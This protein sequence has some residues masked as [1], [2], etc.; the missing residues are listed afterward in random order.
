MAGA[1]IVGCG[2]DRGDPGPPGGTSGNGSGEGGTGGTAQGGAGAR[3]GTGQVGSGEAGAAQ[4]GENQGG[5]GCGSLEEAVQ[6]IEIVSGPPPSVD[7][8]ECWAADAHRLPRPAFARAVLVTTTAFGM[9]TGLAQLHLD[10]WDEVWNEFDVNVSSGPTWG[11]MPVQIDSW[12]LLNMEQHE[13]AV[14]AH[15]AAALYEKSKGRVILWLRAD[16]DFAYLPS[17]QD[18]AEYEDYRDNVLIPQ[19]TLEAEWAEKVEAEYFGVTI[20]E[21]QRFF[22]DDNP[23][24]NSLDDDERLAHAQTLADMLY[25]A[26]RPK[27]DGTLL[28]FDSEKLEVGTTS[29]WLEL[30]LSAYDEI[31]MPLLL[32]CSNDVAR[33]GDFI[34]WNL[35]AFA[36]R[37]VAQGVP[38]G[39]SEVFLWQV[40]EQCPDATTFAPES[41]LA[42]A[43]LLFE[44]ID[45]MPE[46]RRPVGLALPGWNHGSVD[47]YDPATTEAIKSYF[48]SRAR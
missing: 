7:E 1:A 48:S 11:S 32:D 38:W 19:Q 2:G 6:S 17:F 21:F 22:N 20:K 16:P 8:L 39:I 5:A 14:R 10:L 26:V 37:A 18:R 4:G 15:A 30:D 13:Q 27:F 23:Y 33:I 34:E 12:P 24:F 41:Q 9:T 40:G 42:T 43:E 31:R 47:G 45:S 28:A 35:D 25:D 46:G 29:P 36:D 3:A 44:K